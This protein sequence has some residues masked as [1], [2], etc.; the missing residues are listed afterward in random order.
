MPNTSKFIET[1]ANVAVSDWRERKIMLPS[2]V[3]AQAILESG[4]GESELATNANALFGIKKHDWTGAVYVKVAT[5]QRADG[6]YYQI[7]NTEWRAYGSWEE[8]IL[9]HNEYIATR[10]LPTGGLRYEAI[11]GNTDCTAVCKL[12]KECG[13]ATSLTYPDK[14]LNIINTYSLTKYDNGADK[15][16]K[17]AIDAGHGLHTAGKKC[18]KSLDSKQTAEW[19]LND[20]I[21]DKLQQLLASYQC[22]VLR[23]DDTTGAKDVSLADRVKKANEW[24][25][26]MFI[27]IHHN[28]GINGKSGGGIEV[29]YSSSKAE[30]KTQAE[31][32][33]K[34]LIEET[35]LK[36]NRATPVKKYGF[37]VVKK[38]TM[39]AFLI[40]NGFM[41]STTD[42]PV[43][44]TE[45][46]ANKSAQGILK[47]LITYLGLDKV[48]PKVIYRVQCGAFSNRENA[49]K[50]RDKLKADGYEVVIVSGQT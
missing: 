43:I 1:V 46:H 17:I 26:D 32:L 47:F 31:A 48:E 15:M 12:L 6:S 13:Y 36:G 37:Y 19:V 22:E 35:G 25:A 50:L 27:S 30:R 44:L 41:D 8:S 9:D 14:L 49:E 45:A 42:T 21:A 33:Y 2:V 3:I 20:R 16:I 34:S 18:L 11:I 38:T 5:E 29:Y 4:W 24:G 39:P 40:E 10:E 7:E 28:A 23:T